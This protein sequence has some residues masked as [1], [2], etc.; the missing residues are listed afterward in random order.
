VRAD[1]AA[2]A[3]AQA[4]AL[5]PDDADFHW[6]AAIAYLMT[7]RFDEGWREHE[8]RWQAQA[9]RAKHLLVNDDRQWTGEEDLSGK[10]VL[11]FAEQGF[12]DSFQMLRY[13]PIVAERAK[14]VLL[15]LPV[16]LHGLALTSN[17]APGVTSLPPGEKLPEFD[18]YSPLMSL[19][20][21][22]RSDEETIPRAI[23]YLKAD[24]AKAATWRR[25]LEA[26]NG[27]LTVGFVW[28]GSATHANDANRSMTLANLRDRLPSN[29]F[30]VSLQKQVRDAD[31]SILD[32]WQEMHD[33]GGDL[34]DFD[35]TAALIESLDL[36]VSVDTSV[37]HLA[38]ALGRP[39]WV[40]LPHSPDWRWM[41][42]RDDSPWYPTARLYRQ[43][44]PGD[45]AGVIDG[46]SR[47]MAA[48]SARS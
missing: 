28:S 15:H 47:D 30:L 41:L 14:R 17:L 29:A 8:W 26:A 33:W 34:E 27:R 1:E 48:L 39:L 31:R 5:F 43:E 36:V 18:L 3:C 7:G 42:E 23:P 46:L 9:S 37:A 12:G 16:G 4:L 45:W 40:M 38:G 24:P 21:A 32:S 25:R 35:D 20:L 6:N 2:Q 22:F 10:T 19:P 44:S 13:V 11:L